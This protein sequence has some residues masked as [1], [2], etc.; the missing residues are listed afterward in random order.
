MLP[1][2]A[3]DRR[4]RRGSRHGPGGVRRRQPSHRTGAGRGYPITV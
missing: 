1:V 2:R 4:G 3:P